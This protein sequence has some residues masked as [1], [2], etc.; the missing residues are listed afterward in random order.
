M[1]LVVYRQ[2]EHST[3]PGVSGPT[4]VPTTAPSELLAE[5]LDPQL[6]TPWPQARGTTAYAAFSS[7]LSLAGANLQSWPRAYESS[8]DSLVISGT[9]WPSPGDY[10]S[11][12]DTHWPSLVPTG[13]HLVPT[14]Y[15]L[16]MGYHLILKSPLV[17]TCHH[18]VPSG[19]Q[20]PRNQR[21]LSSESFLPRM[22]FRMKFCH[23]KTKNF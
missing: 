12:P 11:S 1:E 17:P 3:Q 23:H 19:H 20:C 4:W 21:L 2:M 16:G 10:E 9:L 22:F 15:R 7:E 14:S 8:S 13:H 18:L 5:A 6:Q